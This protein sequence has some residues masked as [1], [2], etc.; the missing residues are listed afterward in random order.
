MDPIHNFLH[1]DQLI[2]SIIDTPVYQRLRN[3][4]QL[5]TTSYVFQGA[6]HT[7]FE[8]SL[9]VGHLAQSFIKNIYKH[10]P[11]LNELNSEER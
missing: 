3:I 4:K 1:F 10:Q 9:G 2:W 8:H 11:D 7:R 6:N 5:G